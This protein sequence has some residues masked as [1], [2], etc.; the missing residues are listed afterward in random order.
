MIK[1][2]IFDLDGVV[3]DGE[4]SRFNLLKKLLGAKGV[5]LTEDLFSKLVGIRTMTFLQQYFL[6]KLTPQELEE[7]YSQRISE[8]KN[9]PEKYIIPL[10]FIKE[11]LQKLSVE[12]RLAIG[13]SN[14]TSEIE[15][16]LSYISIRD[17]FE[18]I[19]SSTLVQ[20]P[21]PAPDIYLA[22]ARGL[23][24]NPDECVIIE[25]SPIGVRAAKAAGIK[26]IAVTYTTPR[27]ELEKTSAA[28]IINNLSE[29]TPEI[30]KSL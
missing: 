14:K 21:K 2:V 24:L 23:G 8:F 17:K 22:A 10:P 19:I 7:I 16:V 9:H 3:T 28:R 1:A 29:L 11:C 27:S 6:D 15:Q 12:F 25:D 26:C 5:N 18:L 20:H 4:R 30:I 13:S